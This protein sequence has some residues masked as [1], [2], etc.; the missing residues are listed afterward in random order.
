MVGC[1]G[2][3][4]GI[5]PANPALPECVAELIEGLATGHHIIDH[6]NV[7]EL[8]MPGRSKCPVDILV[9]QT[10]VKSGLRNRWPH[11]LA[12]VAQQGDFKSSR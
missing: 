4:P 10:K 7:I 12:G 5:D 3:N 8:S 6:G 11:T 2:Q 1:S 9:A